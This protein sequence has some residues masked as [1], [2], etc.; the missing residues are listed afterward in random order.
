[1][2]E[3]LL[4]GLASRSK[5]SYLSISPHSPTSSRP[6]TRPDVLAAATEP[7]MYP[8]PCECQPTAQYPL[9]LQWHKLH[10][11]GLARAITLGF[12]WCHWGNTFVFLSAN[13]TSDHT[14]VFLQEWG[15]YGFTSCTSVK[16]LPILL[17]STHTFID[18]WCI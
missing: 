16:P 4:V 17:L 9:P 3:A 8:A 13:H 7:G 1:M 12:Y 11:C 5:R 10:A 18:I 6:L 14:T 2:V 15:L